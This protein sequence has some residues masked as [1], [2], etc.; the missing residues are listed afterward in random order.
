[1][2][3]DAI[4]NKIREN[5]RRELGQIIESSIATA[6]E[7][8]LPQAITQVGTANTGMNSSQGKTRR[9]RK[10]K[11]LPKPRSS[12][13]NEFKVNGLSTFDLLEL[14]TTSHL[15]VH[16]GIRAEALEPTRF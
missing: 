7:K 3:Q 13:H 12:A 10:T 9:P 11:K 2:L 4:E 8:A 14:L 1:M 16:P 6:L 15:E 5:I